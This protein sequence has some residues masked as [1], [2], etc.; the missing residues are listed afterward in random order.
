MFAMLTG[1]LPFTVEPFNIKQLHL[2]MINGEMNPIPPDIS[3][4]NPFPIIYYYYWMQKID[5]A[6][7]KLFELHLF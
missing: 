6:K 5:S 7:V 3:T 1:T 4:G 2:K